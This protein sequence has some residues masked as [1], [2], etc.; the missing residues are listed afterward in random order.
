[1]SKL[2]I[3]GAITLLTS[4]LTVDAARQKPG[5]A[6]A[7][8]FPLR[9]GDS[10]TYRNTSDE[11]QYTLKVLAEEPQTD[12]ATRYQVELHA[13]VIILKLFSKT[14]EWVLLH[15][16]RYP[17]H[18]GMEAKYEPPRNYLPN[19]PK[20]GF[21]WS[22]KG[23]DYT[24]SEVTEKGEVSGFETVTVPAGNFRAMKVVSEVSSGSAVMTKTY[25]Y[26]DGVGLVKTTTEGGQIK[27]G[28]E[29]TDYSFK[30]KPK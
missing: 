25:W 9:V 29:L 2:A 21:K 18:E 14:K 8:Y 19:T 27:Y 22:W 15:A 11:S 5:K 16:E 4:L 3:F 24:Q 12:G 10:W 17:E 13:G 23:R 28:S 26:A 20:P 30:Q 6:P 1:M 7:D